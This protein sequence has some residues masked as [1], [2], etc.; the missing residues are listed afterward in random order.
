[1]WSSFDQGAGVMFDVGTGSDK[2]YLGTNRISFASSF[3]KKR[4]FGISP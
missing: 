4:E 3:P 2:K 1:M